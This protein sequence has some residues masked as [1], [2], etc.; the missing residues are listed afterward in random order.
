MHIPSTKL[1]KAMLD[2]HANNKHSTL[3]CLANIHVFS[4]NG[5]FPLRVK[6]YYLRNLAQ[7]IADISDKMEQGNQ[8]NLWPHHYLKKNKL[9]SALKA[10]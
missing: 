1:G 2:G 3:N 7:T 6:N 10:S 4:T 5:L 9:H 8:Q